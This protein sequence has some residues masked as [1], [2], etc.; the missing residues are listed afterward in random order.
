I[1]SVRWTEQTTSPDFTKTYSFTGTAIPLSY[2]AL[3]QVEGENTCDHIVSFSVEQTA[4]EGLNYSLQSYE[5]EWDSQ[6]YIS[7]SKE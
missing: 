7:F 3:F 2:G 1:D 5:C 4:P 6:I